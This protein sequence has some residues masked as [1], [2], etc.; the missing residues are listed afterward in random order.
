MSQVATNRPDGSAT[1]WCMTQVSTT[2]L[3]P[4]TSNTTY[5]C[6]SASRVIEVVGGFQSFEGCARGFVRIA[7]H[8][9][10][11]ANPRVV[12]IVTGATTEP[13]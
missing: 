5:P 3:P 9:L 12:I 6:G 13:T 8:I 2:L 11:G 1:A 10:T 4:S 7:V